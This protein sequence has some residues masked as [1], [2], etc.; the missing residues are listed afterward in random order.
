MTNAIHQSSSR[1]VS[2]PITH[3]KKSEQRK[4]LPSFGGVYVVL[5]DRIPIYIGTS[6]C[7]CRRLTAGNHP[8]RLAP[9]D[10]VKARR[11]AVK[12][13]RGD[14]GAYNVEGRLIH[15]L[16]PMLNGEPNRSGKSLTMTCQ[17]TQSLRARVDAALA[18]FEPL[19]NLVRMALEA[20]VARREAERTGG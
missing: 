7:I 19:A 15:R 8:A 13:K 18:P 11:V 1:W 9:G 5:R 14:R 17:V 6:V 20:E 10:V 3:P 16:R 12:A 2:I 4:A